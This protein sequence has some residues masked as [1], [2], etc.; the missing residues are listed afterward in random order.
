MKR[1]PLKRSTKPIPKRRSKPRRGPLRCPAYR[2]WLKD[3]RCCV[4]PWQP[5]HMLGFVPSDPAHTQNNGMRSKGSDASCIP[6]CRTHHEEFDS[7]R[8]SFQQKYGVDADLEATTYYETFLAS[9][10]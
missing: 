2:A 7:G 9:R 10:N 1:T 8:K 5:G 3:K 6:L 4:C